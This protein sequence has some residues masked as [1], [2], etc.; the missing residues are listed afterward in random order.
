MLYSE[1][2]SSCPRTCSNVYGVSASLCD[3]DRCYS[4]CQCPSGTF[5]SATD[6][7]DVAYGYSTRAAKNSSSSLTCVPVEQCPCRYQGRQ[8]PPGSVVEANCN[9]WYED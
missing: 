7:K 4:G 2:T 3:S 1:C 8:Y 5:L 9:K 6:D